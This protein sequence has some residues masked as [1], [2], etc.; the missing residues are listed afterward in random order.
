MSIKIPVSASFDATDLKAQIQQVNDQI[1]VLANQVSMANKQ[2]FNPIN[3]RSKEDLTAFTAQMQKLL[4]IQTE[5]AGQMQKTGQAGKS[6]LSADWSKMYAD[7][8]QRMKKMQSMLQFLGVEFENLPTPKPK[9]PAVQPPAPTTA[10][11][12]AP[13]APAVSQWGNA[14]ARVF[15][16]ALGGFG[17]AGN[18]ASG[19]INAGI[20][21]GAG[22]GLAGLIG[23][24]GALAAGAVISKVM[25]SVG[26]S[27]QQA[28]AMD[29]VIRAT[30]IRNASLNG[31]RAAFYSAANGV[32][33]DINAF[34]N[35]AGQYQRQSGFVGGSMALATE[36]QGIGQFAR[37]FGLEPSE[38]A[39]PFAT[40]RRLNTMSN[41]AEFQ[42]LGLLIG[43]GI[44]K[45]GAFS[46]SQQFM[47]A[48]SQF[49][50]MQARQSL[51]AP[52]VGAFAGSLASLVSSKTPGLDV[53]NSASLLN[54]ANNAMMNGGSYGEAS[55]ALTA[56]AFMRA[57]INDPFQ[58]RLLS[59]AGMF[60]TPNSVMG[61][62]SQYA[63]HFGAKNFGA[64][65]NQSAFDLTRN[66]L[67]RALGSNTKEYYAAMS[68][69][70]GVGYAQAMALG[71][72]ST[73]DLNSTQR[74]LKTAGVDINSVNL[75]SI[76]DLMRIQR[77]GGRAVA[78]ELLGRSGANA[79]AT[80]DR[81]RLNQALASGNKEQID[82]VTTSIV[83]AT[84]QTKTEGERTR[85]SLAAVKNTIQQYSDKAIP[86]LNT[87]MQALVTLTGKA[88][89]Q[90]RR[91]Y[92]EAEHKENLSNI[93]AQG[94]GDV[95]AAEEKLRQWQMENAAKVKDKAYFTQ[96][97]A[98]KQQIDTAR[99]A[100]A[101]SETIENSR[102]NAAAATPVSAAARE[103]ISGL[104][105]DTSAYQ[106]MQ[107]MSS[108]FEAAAKEYGVDAN[109]LRSIAATESMF[110]N[111]RS[112]KNAGG[113]MQVMPG[114]QKG[115]DM[116]K[117][118]DRI[119]AGARMWADAMKQA[120]GDKEL[121]AR[122]YNGG[123]P[124]YGNRENDEFPLKVEQYRNQIE[125]RY[126]QMNKIAP[127]TMPKQGGEFKLT[128][129]PVTVNVVDSSGRTVRSHEV[130][131]KSSFV[132][133]RGW[134]A[135]G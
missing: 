127:G 40:A 23:G 99:A 8:A 86:L 108:D 66:Q 58:S 72:M 123:R 119:R 36:A 91:D 134:S 130:P 38:A 55:Q 45:S 9:P 116:S 50:S 3:L 21:A 56:R 1:R 118:S 135:R 47:E 41:N 79:L 52:N 104:K 14:G 10:R 131:M 88:P 59:Q 42:K 93:R 117:R 71:D 7:Q 20:S 12:P 22:A 63:A 106:R 97:N 84:G 67:R 35:Y 94:N 89:G 129:D 133:P 125:G 32:G 81:E 69:H 96:E 95:Q 39:G 103:R 61:P 101:R 54:Q 15:H 26:D 49:I 16:G 60:A 27:Q 98:L 24:L 73:T 76:G 112:G 128:S 31:G 64:A 5:L 48:A 28:I 102:Y 34:T 132:Q 62:G 82:K 126:E 68:N 80:S 75:S 25:D 122:I 109:D 78:G 65:G 44:V 57:G 4:K 46:Q 29:K 87:S 2:S 43:E 120:N 83:A 74:Q 110:T 115:F 70:F 37:G 90:M 17:S 114:N 19:A 92:L 113:E 51:T 105:I 11:Q 100:A 53:A 13:T 111:A 124:I 107:S 6:P 77:G 30:G 85:D 121:A 18:V 33:M